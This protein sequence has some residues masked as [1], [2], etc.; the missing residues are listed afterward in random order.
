MDFQLELDFGPEYGEAMDYPFPI[1]EIAHQLPDGGWLYAGTIADEYWGEGSPDRSGY[2]EGNTAYW[3]A[4][5]SADGNLEWKYLH[6]IDPLQQII[7]GLIITSENQVVIS[8]GDRHQPYSYA[9]LRKIDAEGKTVF[10]KRYL[11][12][13]ILRESFAPGFDG[14]IFFWG[15]RSIP[16]GEYQPDLIIYS[17]AKV[18]PEGD[19]VWI[20]TFPNHVN[21]LTVLPLAD[22]SILLSLRGPSLSITLARIDASGQLPDCAT[23]PL[24]S[25]TSRMDQQP[26]LFD[27]AD[28]LPL[29]LMFSTPEAA[30][31][32]ILPQIALKSADPLIIELC[33]DL[34]ER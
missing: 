15:R 8:G 5:F 18:S 16:Q 10:H 22:G 4:R 9:W 2:M 1:L 25:I 27:T 33:R 19:L 34:I 29:S 30:E 3:Y 28:Q 21:I 11:D 13:P 32:T 26:P 24:D 7:H 31:E 17:L 12:L 20:R 6:P 23:L 14:S